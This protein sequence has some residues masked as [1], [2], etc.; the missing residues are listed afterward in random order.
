MNSALRS[1]LANRSFAEVR[2]D[3]EAW[4]RAVEICVGAHLVNQGMA[5]GIDVHYWRDGNDEVDFVLRRGKQVTALE[6]K[7]GRKRAAVS[8]LAEFKKRYPSAKT[9]EVGSGG[10]P[11]QQFLE[12]PVARW[13]RST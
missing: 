9:M 12:T 5:D 3:P 11:L 4:G 13:V 8:G 2:G 10:V 6:V 1:A 7:S